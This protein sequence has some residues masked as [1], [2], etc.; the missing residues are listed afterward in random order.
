[1]YQF[2]NRTL[3]VFQKHF[4]G[5]LKPGTVSVEPRQEQLVVENLD[6]EQNELF[7]ILFLLFL[8]GLYRKEERGVWV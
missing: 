7:S 8:E 5:I 2:N 4:R 1:M 6:P 3:R